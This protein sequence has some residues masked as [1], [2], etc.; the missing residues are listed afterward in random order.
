MRIQFYLGHPAH[1]HL[2]KNVIAS[3]KARD[4]QVAVLIK[5]KDILE[6]LLREAKIPYTNILSEGR[7]DSKL[8]ILIG[9]LKRDFRSWKFAK[10][11]KPDILVGTSVE[12]SHLT[13]IMGVPSININEDDADAVPFYAK[14]SY[15][16][17]SEIISPTVCKNGKWEKKSVKYN[18]YHELAYLHPNHFTPDRKKVEKY[19]CSDEPYFILRFARLKAHHDSGVTGIDTR[20]AL[21]LLDILK[22]YGKIY[23]TSEIE[24]AKELE[25]YRMEINPL[26]IHHVLAF[27]KMY[28]GDS[29]T[30]AAEAGVLGTPFI[31]Y[32]DFVGKIGY[33]D[34]LEN[35]YLL[36]YGIKPNNEKDLFEK[37]T[38]IASDSDFKTNHQINREKMLSEKIDFAK[39]LIWFIENYP[40]SKEEYELNQDKGINY[41]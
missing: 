30:M 29:Q 4:H 14:L 6:D 37:V 22:P 26:D 19:F 15:P 5:K 24:L 28:I 38:K 39:F 17:A 21:Q 35:K 23:I 31:R 20:I 8:G 18:G 3:L 1:F 13:K 9:M 11:F 27:A 25:R 2:L 34:E 32:N 16:W 36:G 40:Q 12:N 33:L 7:K 41:T 10:K